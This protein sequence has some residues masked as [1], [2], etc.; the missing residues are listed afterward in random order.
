MS[1]RC[2]QIGEIVLG[3]II[4][5]HAVEPLGID[6]GSLVEQRLRYITETFPASQHQRGPPTGRSGIDLGALVEKR[7]DHVTVAVLR[8]HV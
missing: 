5:G 6:L 3:G 4:S 2:N 1:H 8:S 7:L